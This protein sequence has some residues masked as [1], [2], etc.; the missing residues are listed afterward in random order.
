MAKRFCFSR[1]WEGQPVKS[2][3]NKGLA[4][5]DPVYVFGM[6]P[7]FVLLLLVV[8]VRVVFGGINKRACDSLGSC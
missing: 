5:N 7:S 8:F 1:R 2:L 4:S 3:M 6:A